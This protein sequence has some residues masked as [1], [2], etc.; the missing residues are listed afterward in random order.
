MVG[1]GMGVCTGKE[2]EDGSFQL[3]PRKVIDTHVHLAVDRAEAAEGGK[4][5]HNP[6]VR[7]C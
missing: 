6:W 2:R 3:P 5:L 1:R 7:E 4:G